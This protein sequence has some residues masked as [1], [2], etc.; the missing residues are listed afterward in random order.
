M[1]NLFATMLIFPIMGLLIKILRVLYSDADYYFENYLD[2]SMQHYLGVPV[3]SS[4]ERSE[5]RSVEN[6]QPDANTMV[7]KEAETEKPVAKSVI[8]VT[9]KTRSGAVYFS[10]DL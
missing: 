8:R 5:R 4:D 1:E 2:D 10:Y 6:L 3:Q 9:R 7:Q